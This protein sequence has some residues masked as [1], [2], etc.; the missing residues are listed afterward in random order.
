MTDFFK[1][2]ES[3][4]IYGMLKLIPQSFQDDLLRICLNPL[5]AQFGNDRLQSLAET[6]LL[7]YN[8]SK[9]SII[10]LG[11]KKARDELKTSFIE[12][13][14]SL[15]GEPVKL[16]SSESYLGDQIGDSVSSSITL[17]I[18]KREG[19]AKKS[20]FE[21]KNIMEDCRIK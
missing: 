6:K 2:S 16:V 13:P 8:L 1:D 11:E 12:N 4:V 5:S 21:I 20:I 14:P 18:D 9:T 3:E 17:T 15:F 10:F 7:S 19:L